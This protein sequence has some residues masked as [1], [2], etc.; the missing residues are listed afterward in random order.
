M[1]QSFRKVATFSIYCAIFTANCGRSLFVGRRTASTACQSV[2]RSVDCKKAIFIYYV[3][4][5]W[6]TLRSLKL[7]GK[8]R[9][10]RT[11]FFYEKKLKHDSK[12]TSFVLMRPHICEYLVF[13]IIYDKR[14]KHYVSVAN[15]RYDYTN[16]NYA[17]CIVYMIFQTVFAFLTLLKDDLR[18]IKENIQWFPVKFFRS[19]CRTF[20]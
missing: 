10:E 19:A 16:L 20:F 5:M 3:A 15:F 4:L 13:N 11:Y 18:E 8:K 17:S 12:T 2:R 1:L 6:S 7:T 14:G 9:C